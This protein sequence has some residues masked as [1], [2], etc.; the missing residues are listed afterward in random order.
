MDPY[1]QP[2]P[3]QVEQEARNWAM[4][5]H[6]AALSGYLTAVGFIVGPVI[7]WALKKDQ[8]DFVNDQGKEAI[9]FNISVFIYGIV[10]AILVFLLIGIPLLVVLGIFHLIMVIVAAI[11][12]SNGTPYRYPLTIRF[13]K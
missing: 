9:N 2:P 6:L 13:I 7:V 5:T 11:S 8:F 4:F 10:S 3:G 1:S 12:A